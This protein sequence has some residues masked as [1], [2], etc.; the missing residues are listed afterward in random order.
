MTENKNYRTLVLVLLTLVYGFNFIDRQIVGILAPFIQEDLGLTN[1]QI[2][3][4]TGLLFAFFYTIIAIPIAWLADRYSRVNIVSL[5]LAV[6]SGFTALT[7]IAN[8][9]LHIGLAR[10]GVGVGE[11]GGSPPSH[12]IISDLFPKEERT[13]ALGIYSLGIPFGIM[14]AYFTVAAIA[15]KSTADVPW[16]RIFILLGLTG[17]GLALIV[18]LVLREPKRGAMENISGKESA[19]PQLFSK[20]L[21]ILLTIPTWWAMCFGISVASFVAYSLSAFQT[22]YIFL[23]EPDFN[24]Q[25][26]MIALGI[27]NGIAYAGGTFLGGYI[28]NKWGKRNV[29]AYGWVP[30]IA[31]ALAAPCGFAAIYIG[32]VWGHLAAISVF[33]VFLGMYLGPSFAIAQTLAPIHMRAMSTALFFFILNMIALGGGPTITGMLIDKLLIGNDTLHAIR[34]A[35]SIV[36]ILLLLASVF[37]LLAAKYLPKDWADAQRRNEGLAEGES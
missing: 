32:S 30:A 10:M 18:R 3:L 24:L 1:T 6:W 20:S 33:L 23:L 27:I 7:G 14:F 28:A 2:G 8:S 21:K 4:L 25:T 12:S 19:K 29:R 15:G 26:L 35:F 17:V 31:V 37:F 13:K 9:F 34:Y 5:A 36:G 11:A 22:K 16:R